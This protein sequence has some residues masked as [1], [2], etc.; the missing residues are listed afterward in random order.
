[1][2]VIIVC[3][4][5]AYVYLNSDMYTVNQV[6][7]KMDSMIR[8]K[9]YKQMKSVANNKHTYIFLRSLSSKDKV[10]DTSNFQGGSDK[11]AYYVT[12]VKSQK[13]AVYMRKTGVVS[14]E[15]RHVEKQ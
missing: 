10:S 14:W 1:M 4:V 15:I 8:E 7:S 6:N 13:L 2:L 12:A 11:N 5:V 3:G 9:N